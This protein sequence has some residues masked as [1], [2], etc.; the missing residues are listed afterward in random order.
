MVRTFCW[1]WPL[2]IVLSLLALGMLQAEEAAIE[3]A[4]RAQRAQAELQA[5]IDAADDERREMLAELRRLETDTHRLEERSDALAPRLERQGERLSRREEA[6]ASLAETRDVL[7]QLEQALVSHLETW[8]VGDL[9]FLKDQRLARVESLEAGLDDP[10][11]SAAERLERLLAAWRTEL[12][13][14][15]EL[16]AWRGILNEGDE[17]D[18]RREVDFLRLGRVGLYF[19]TPD[20]R[21]GGVWRADVERWQALNEAERVEL[22]H[23]LRIARDQRAPELLTLPISHPLQRVDVG[24][25]L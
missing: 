9:P 14:G 10:D 4:S 13:Y 16:D 11:A 25:A 20:G 15:R 21:E 7:P 24:E 17:G 2:G 1:Q 19:L 8:V 12:D 23:G 22:R 18:A 6:L 3:D 5:R